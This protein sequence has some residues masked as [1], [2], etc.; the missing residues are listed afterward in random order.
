MKKLTIEIVEQKS[1]VKLVYPQ[2]QISG[3]M[4]EKKYK[5]LTKF[6]CSD[7]MDDEGGWLHRDCFHQ[8]CNNCAYYPIKE[9]F[10]K[11]ND[12]PNNYTIDFLKA[13]I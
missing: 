4:E 7:I 6:G 9:K 1:G 8:D 11:E 10:D 12:L 5:E 13:V 3:S 2:Q